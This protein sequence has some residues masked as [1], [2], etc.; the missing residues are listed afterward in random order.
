MKVLELMI[1]LECVQG[2]PGG[3]AQTLDSGLI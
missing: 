1:V 3:L 2:G